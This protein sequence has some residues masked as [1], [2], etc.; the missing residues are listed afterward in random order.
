M[1]QRY[2]NDRN[3][4]RIVFLIMGLITAV[5]AVIVPF[6]KMNTGVND[7]VLGS[8]LLCLGV[9]A[10]V[11]MPMAGPLSS[12]Y[13][14][15]KLILVS[16]I[17][18]LVVAPFL[19]FVSNAV[20]LGGFLILFGICVGMNDC[21]MNVQ[22]IIIEKRE[23]KPLMSGFHGMYSMGGIIGAGLMTGLLALKL[24]IITST[25]LMLALIIGLFVISYRH[26]LP[27][28]NP[29]EGPAFAMPKGV[30]L[31]F[32]IIC[33]VVFLVEGTAL[34]WSAV[35]LVDI[36][37]ISDTLGG[38]G[39]AVF[40]VAMT[41]GR[42]SGDYIISKVG[43]LPVVIIGALTTLLGFYCIITGNQLNMILIGYFFIGAGCSNIVPV[44]FNQ[45]GRQKTMPQKVAVPAVTTLGYLGIL[46]GPAGIGF[47]AHHSSL[48]HAFVFV[49]MLMVI[50]LVLAVLL[51][52]TF[53]ENN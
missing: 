21:A 43:A 52:K 24:D 49:A 42:L 11:A 48:P 16:T 10:L 29:P 18:M 12:R 32:G 28:A 3:A 5:W 17:I 1:L 14:C 35:Y 25:F 4:T 47:I 34:D 36:K 51:Q 26:L 13:G 19:S 31:V 38:L 46:A 45:I 2:M 20:L 27:Y 15:Q 22:A 39:F 30:V 33:F 50:V 8:L 7:G 53:K 9:G 40:A 37:K 41:M 23:N 44:M 6:A